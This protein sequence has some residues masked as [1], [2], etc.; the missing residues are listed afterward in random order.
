MNNT[1]AGYLVPQASAFLVPLCPELAAPALESWAFHASGAG[2]FLLLYLCADLAAKKALPDANARWFALHALANIIT[3]GASL[4][5]LASVLS[6]PMCGMVSPILSWVPT[7]A[8]IAIHIYRACGA[9]RAARYPLIPRPPALNRPP[10]PPAPPVLSLQTAL[11]SG[12]C[13]ARTTLC[14]T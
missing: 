7:H 14:T 12:R 5:D 4:R 9:L 10:P 3:A 8:G 2:A 11:A 6:R 13:C 1:A